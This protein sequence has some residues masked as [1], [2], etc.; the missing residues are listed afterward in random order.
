MMMMLLCY[1]V[2]RE[3]STRITPIMSSEFFRIN[4][5]GSFHF[6]REIPIEV[7][8]LPITRD[9]ILVKVIYKSKDV[10][11]IFLCRC[12]QGFYS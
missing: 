3:S 6:I 12:T 2:A 7:A 11:K 10:N 5:S 8:T 1:E 9:Y 4:Q